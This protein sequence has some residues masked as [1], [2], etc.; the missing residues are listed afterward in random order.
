[1]NKITGVT[2]TGLDANTNL[3]GA[4][5]LS[6]KYPIEWGILFGGRLGKNRYPHPETVQTFYGIGLNLAFH[7]CGPILNGMIG[8]DVSLQIPDYGI[9]FEECRRV[10]VNALKYDLKRMGEFS[11]RIHRPVIIQSRGGFPGELLPW[12]VYPLFD[13]SGGKGK[14]VSGFPP[15]GIHEHVGY[16]GGINPENVKDVFEQA[17]LSAYTFWLDMESGVR[18][19]D[20][21]DLEKCARVCEAIWN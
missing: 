6:Q 7:L 8:K 3:E 4:L 17:A 13:E 1:M 21:L 9:D 5:G 15:Q 19:D 12:G 14:M 20:W 18:T 2:F 10:Q 16:A 11:A